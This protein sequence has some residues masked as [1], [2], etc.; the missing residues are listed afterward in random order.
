[1]LIGSCS[2]KRNQGL[3]RL[4]SAK[5]LLAT[6]MLRVKTRRAELLVSGLLEK[7]KKKRKKVAF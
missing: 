2:V 1:M 4:S 3:P 7:K 5:H 6:E